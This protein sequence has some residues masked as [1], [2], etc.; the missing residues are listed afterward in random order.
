MECVV[1]VGFRTC[2]D[3]AAVVAVAVFENER[4]GI[5]IAEIA[6]H[7]LYPVDIAVTD[8]DAIGGVH[9]AI[10]AV[11][12]G[13]IVAEVVEHAFFVGIGEEVSGVEHG[14]EAYM[15]LMFEFF[16]QVFEPSRR[17]NDIKHAGFEA[18]MYMRLFRFKADGSFR[19][20]LFVFS[21]HA[22]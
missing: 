22:F 7:E 2:L 9:L 1:V 15:G 19:Q 11:E 18:E 16:D 8:I 5:R 17:R 12:V 20:L 13:D 10:L 21:F 4:L 6:F 14:S 3:F